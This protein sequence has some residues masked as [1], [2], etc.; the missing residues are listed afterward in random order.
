MLAVLD[1]I[2]NRRSIREY[3]PDPVP[4]DVIVQLLDCARLAPSAS[5]RQPWRF[6]VL[7][8]LSIKKELSRCAYGQ[9]F[10]ESAPCMIVCCVDLTAYA[11]NGDGA[12]TSEL[13]GYL[14]E[15]RFNSAIGTEHIVLAAVAFGLGTCWVH[16]FDSQK[17]H[18]L[19]R[20]PDMTAVVTLL[21]LG[22]PAESPPLRPRLPL[23]SIIL[24]PI[25]EACSLEVHGGT[26]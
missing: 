8:D 3:K 5:N 9:H 1:A 21:A 4:D 16:L 15:C 12:S 22:Y 26:D 2:K 11:P 23:K 7:K 25:P 6:V 19:L 18:E 24:T 10:V 20:L 13:Y 14:G 17:V